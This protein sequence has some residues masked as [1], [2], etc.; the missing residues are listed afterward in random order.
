MAFLSLL[1][2]GAEDVQHCAD[3][4]AYPRSAAAQTKSTSC[5]QSQFSHRARAATAQEEPKGIVAI[6]YCDEGFKEIWPVF[7]GCYSQAMSCESGTCARPTIEL[8]DLGLDTS[9]DGTHCGPRASGVTLLS[10]GSR[11]S[12]T[13]PGVP[14][15]ISSAI[16]RELMGG[17]DVLRLDADAFLLQYPFEKIRDNY[18]NAHIVSS[19]DCAWN[20]QQYCGWYLDQTYLNHHGGHDPLADVGFML[21][22]GFMYLR[23][24]PVTIE[25]AREA[26]EA[27]RS[28]NTTFEQIAMNEVLATRGCQWSQ[29]DTSPSPGG[30][31][32]L[33]L[34]GNQPLYGSCGGLN[35]VVLP[36]SVVT[37]TP[38]EMAGKIAVH[39]GG[40]KLAFLPNISAACQTTGA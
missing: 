4:S 10:E 15:L 36:Y 29:Q 39:P 28:G 7:Y 40:E 6:T 34:L 27:V 32:A 5:L 12:L 8:L 23:S 25:F 13:P 35:V 17:R 2:A 22:T 26:E 38:W 30:V 19:T 31:E 37:R 16:T 14:L 9:S 21:N 11:H 18:P 1:V 20:G 24:A 3:S 33:Y